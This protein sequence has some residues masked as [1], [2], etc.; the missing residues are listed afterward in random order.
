MAGFWTEIMERD[1]PSGITPSLLLQQ[2][3]RVLDAV[4]S[5]AE[6]APLDRSVVVVPGDAVNRE[7]RLATRDCETTSY[8]QPGS[9]RPHRLVCGDRPYSTARFEQVV[10]GVTF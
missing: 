7:N 2:V 5:V 6:Q 9:L 3:H 1:Y 8:L 4:V 10:R